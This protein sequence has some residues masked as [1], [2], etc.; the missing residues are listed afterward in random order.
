MTQGNNI[1]GGNIDFGRSQGASV[2]GS[3]TNTF[4][5]GSGERTDQ[6]LRLVTELQQVIARHERQLAD[7]EGL[8]ESVEML[9][10]Q[11]ESGSPKPG[12]LRAL[13]AGMGAMAGN[14]TAISSAV[15]AVRKA[16]G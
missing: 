4:N 6:L 16:I 9:R 1:I 3:N 13:L 8:R 5:N 12:P 2:F 15:D 11:V 10:E 14:V 7:A